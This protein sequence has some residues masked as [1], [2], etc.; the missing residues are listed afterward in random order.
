MRGVLFKKVSLLFVLAVSV[1]LVK[2]QQT[3]QKFIQETQYLLYL[4]EGYGSDTTTR[5]PLILFLHGSGESGTDLEKIKVHGP[6]K[7]IEAGK[8]FPFIVVSPQAPPQT[9][10]K[11]EVL[12]GLLGDIKKKYRVDN[13]RVYLTGLSMGGFGTWD[14]SEK[15]PDEFAAI[16]PIC[17]GGDAGKV[18]KLRHMPVWCF[19]GAKDNVVPVA[20]S[21]IMVDA[22]RKYNPG[23]KFTIYPEADHNSWEVTYNNDSLYT[24][25]L[26]Q[27]KFRYKPV[28]VQQK[29]LKEYEGLYTNAKN[30]T[31]KIVLEN[32]KLIAKPGRNTIELKA[33]SDTN[34]FWDTESVNEVQ[35]LRDKKGTVTG[36]SILTDEKEE[37]RKI[38]A[39]KKAR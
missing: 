1:T 14:L 7:L 37:A 9:G 32:E 16:A 21:Q 5:W 35:F 11:A 23:V 22:L 29:I 19:H 38:I 24:W 36:L 13:D 25:F 33:S 30:D 26:S 20:S 4:P 15:Y 17:G 34:F 12:K 39:A 31:L 2:A 27:K 8:K 3:A 18:W 28:M 6:P 10:W